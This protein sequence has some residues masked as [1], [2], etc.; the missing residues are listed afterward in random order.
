MAY[1]PIN[2]MSI[3]SRCDPHLAFRTSNGCIKSSRNQNQ[4][5]IELIGQR[6]QNL[7]KNCHIICITK[8]KFIQRNI[9]I[10]SSGWKLKK[11]DIVICTIATINKNTN[12]LIYRW[13][14]WS[15][16]LIANNQAIKARLSV[17]R[18]YFVLLSV[19]NLI[20]CCLA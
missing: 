16:Q 6:N 13:I 1:L 5:R 19:K 8:T 3:C 12:N 17:C 15:T 20:Q 7:L 10:F 18:T 14:I 2:E 11:M 4:I 9:D